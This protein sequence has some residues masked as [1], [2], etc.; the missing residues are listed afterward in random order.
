MAKD[1]NVTC[2]SIKQMLLLG[3]GMFLLAALA[4]PA[5]A[6]DMPIAVPPA[7]AAYK[8]P[9]PCTLT[10]C[11]G[12]Y[13]GGGLIGVGSNMDV[14]GGGIANSVFAGGGATALDAGYRF[15]NGAYVFVIEGVGG[16]E[17][18]WPVSISGINK[19]NRSA[20][21]VRRGPPNTRGYCLVKMNG[22]CEGRC[23]TVLTA[24]G[25]LV[26]G[27]GTA[28]WLGLQEMMGRH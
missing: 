27:L 17:I 3:F 5:Q 20:W 6:A 13:V 23:M 12:F 22:H 10:A 19:A 16:Y 24:I 26:T 14:L 8:T 21:P 7:K 25:A 11:S 4:V 9:T 28:V 18:V 1:G 2:G 15:W